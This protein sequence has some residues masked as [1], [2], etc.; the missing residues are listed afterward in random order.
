LPGSPR[1]PHRLDLQPSGFHFQ[2]ICR[3]LLT[4]TKIVLKSEAAPVFE[5][6]RTPLSVLLYP[7]VI[8]YQESK[9]EIYLTD[10]FA[11]LAVDRLTE[12]GVLIAVVKFH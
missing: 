1:P 12:A 9:N 8:A 4:M 6:L 10:P 5:M 3:V 2:T 7:S 11:D